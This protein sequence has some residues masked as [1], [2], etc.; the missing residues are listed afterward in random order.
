MGSSVGGGPSLPEGV[1]AA[2]GGGDAGL[3]GG[4]SLGGAVGLEAAMV[5]ALG[6]GDRAGEPAK[7]AKNKTAPSTTATATAPS[8]SGSGDRAGGGG[9]APR[10]T[11][12]NEGAVGC[13]NG[14]VAPGGGPQ[15]GGGP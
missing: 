5:V 3:L 2:D 6:S 10:S 8:T 1:G 11:L 4:G 13:P 7:N 14:W 15:P 9:E 12:G